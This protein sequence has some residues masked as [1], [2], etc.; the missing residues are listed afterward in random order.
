M[1][2]L[3][4]RFVRD[5][6][7]GFERDGRAEAVDEALRRLEPRLSTPGVRA[8]LR[9]ATHADT[10]DVADAEELLFGLDAAVS[11]GTGQLLERLA[12]EL[13]ARILAQGTLSI[14]G[15]L[16]GT[17]ARLQAPLEHLFVG[18]PIGFDLSKKRDGFVLFLGVGGR[19][20]TA[21][22][23]RHLTVG[24][25]RAAQRFARQGMTD[26]VVLASEALGDRVRLE[27]RLGG[28]AA[29]PQAP[30]PPP[31]P[32]R[33]TAATNPSRPHLPTTKPTLEA[34]DRI[35]RRASVTPPA[36]PRTAPEEIFVPRSRRPAI[37]L[38]QESPAPRSDTMPSLSQS[39]FL[40]KRE[41]D[42]EPSS[43]SG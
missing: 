14:S 19:P 42:D 27:A 10:L 33:R 1:P 34:V 18:L 9:A 7:E 23:L 21:R 41:D 43:S 15:D 17:V 24:A 40:T 29:L 37:E 28:A 39:G 3:R 20:R 16:M 22:L 5:L 38:P 8:A 6:V 36:L 4:T 35:I 30:T 11:D 32:P 13:F 12:T 25:V 31:K 26:E 2:G